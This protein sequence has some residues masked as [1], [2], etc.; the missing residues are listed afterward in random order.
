ME[1]R[2][3]FQFDD[4][5]AVEFVANVAPPRS[6]TVAEVKRATVVGNPM[7]CANQTSEMEP[8][9]VAPGE[10]PDH[11]GVDYDQIMRYFDNLKVGRKKVR[12]DWL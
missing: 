11:L 4:E 10:L 3:V 12:F 8:A 2:P 5:P 6:R 1:G 7:C 9:G